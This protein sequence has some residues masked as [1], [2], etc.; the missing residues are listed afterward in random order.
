[1]NIEEKKTWTITFSKDEIQSVL[2]FFIKEDLLR[3]ANLSGAD[4]SGAELVHTN[5]GNTNC[6]GALLDGI[7]FDL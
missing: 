6:S 7:K 1:M 4:L 2:A 5:L 3:G